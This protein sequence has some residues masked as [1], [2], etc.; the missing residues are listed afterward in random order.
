[1]KN[2]YLFLLILIIIT[3]LQAQPDIDIV[4]F[5]NSFVSPVSIKN[6]G[7][8]RLFVVEKRGWIKIV[9]TDG[10][11]NVTPF[12]NIDNLV[13]DT[14]SERGLLG[15]AFHPNY[16]SNGYFYVNYINNSGNTVISRF[17]RNVSDPN[18]ANPSSETILMTINQ[19]F[20]NHNGGDLEFGPDGYLYIGTGDGGSGGDPNG[21]GQ[22]LNSLLGKMLRIDVDSGSPYSIPSDNPYV[23]DANP[24]TLAEIWAYGLRNPWRFSFDSTTGDLWIA[25]VGQNIYEEINTAPSTTAGI[26]YGWRCYEGNHAYNTSGCSS[27][28]GM[29]FPVAEYSHSGGGCSITGGYIYR[30]SVFSNLNGLYLFADYCSNEIGYLEYNGSTWDL[31]FVYKSSFGGNNWTSFGE[32]ING[33]IYIAGISSG[34]IFKI[35][36]N[37]LSVDEFSTLNFKMF[38]NPSNNLVEI[39]VSTANEGLYELYDITGKRVKSFKESGSFNFSVK[40][41]NNGVYFMKCTIDN[42]TFVKKLVVY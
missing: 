31:N 10:S 8:D 3:P 34:K 12:L 1:M 4:E 41:L 28:S 26:N 16:A 35:V 25:D 36:D 24:N 14:G 20:S 23:N 2:Y 11:V 15:L 27:S 21:N 13:I 33:E 18:L 9:N 42:A 32:D 39:D 40:D 30:G 5:A 19:P 6:A 17:S 37:N 7:D 22:N 29:M 38:P